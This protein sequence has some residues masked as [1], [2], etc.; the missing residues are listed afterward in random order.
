MLESF[1]ISSLFI[2]LI[3][4]TLHLGNFTLLKRESWGHWNL[5]S[6]V[7]SRQCSSVGGLLGLSE[8]LF[9][10]DSCLVVS[11]FSSPGLRPEHSLLVTPHLQCT[12]LGWPRR[13]ANHKHRRTPH[14][15]GRC[16]SGKKKQQQHQRRWERV[17]AKV[18]LAP[19]LLQ[20]PVSCSWFITLLGW[21]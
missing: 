14:S 2:Y 21:Q 19:V 3:C 10:E 16:S 6:V 5:T 18:F 20:N 9:W 13:E 7:F 4:L 15:P 17:T 12:G 1:R 11:L 8:G